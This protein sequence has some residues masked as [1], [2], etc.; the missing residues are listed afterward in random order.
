MGR[1]LAWLLNFDAELELADPDGYRRSTRMQAT[2]ERLEAQLLPSME[3]ALGARPVVLHEGDP[4]L[5]ATAGLVGVAWC[6][7]PGAFAAIR[8]LGLE[9]ALAPPVEIVR[10]GNHRSCRGWVP[11]GP[12]RP[13]GRDRELDLPHTGYAW[14]MAELELMLARGPASTRWLLK[15]PFGF[16]GRARKVLRRDELVGAART[17][18]EASMEGYG[19]GLQVEPFVDVVAEYSLHGWVPS[20]AASGG[21]TLGRPLR[22]LVG[23][24]GHW[25]G[26]EEAAPEEL[27]EEELC[28]LLHCA[29][30]CGSWLAGAGWYGPFNVEGFRWMDREG[31]LR[32]RPVSEVHARFSMGW[33]AGLGERAAA[34]LE[35]LPAGRRPA[36]RAP[37]G[38]PPERGLLEQEDRAA[39]GHGPYCRSRRRGSSCRGTS[40]GRSGRRSTCA[41]SW[42]TPGPRSGGRAVDDL[43]VEHRRRG[44]GPWCLEGV[45]AL[46]VGRGGEDEQRVDDGRA[47][48][49]APD[50]AD[51]D[52]QEVGA[53]QVDDREVRAPATWNTTLGLE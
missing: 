23:A 43:G 48:C 45:V 32:Y 44:R 25:L 4:P 6:P 26:Y 33:F 3:A 22:Q 17:W 41:R 5:D 15:R 38:R 18:A 53:D 30:S 8:A 29:G 42:S 21:L 28:L 1:R 7:T 50:R 12:P 36:T 9:P 34:L 2:C 16:A 24:D 10:A 35:A 52:R 27:D 46:H 13:Y 20:P 14:T 11:W 19:R 31:R 40:R 47:A 49:A 51:V 39:V 37:W